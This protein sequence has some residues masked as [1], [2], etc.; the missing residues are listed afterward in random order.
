MP[1][2]D[3]KKGELLMCQLCVD[4]C[5]AV[6]QE[7]GGTRGRENEV[8]GEKK[9]RGSAQD[10]PSGIRTSLDCSAAAGAQSTRRETAQGTGTQ[11]LQHSLLSCRDARA[12]VQLLSY[13]GR[14]LE[15]AFCLLLFLLGALHCDSGARWRAGV[16]CAQTLRGELGLDMPQVKRSGAAGSGPV[17]GAER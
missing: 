11:S 9:K 16:L 3:L 13:L 4:A 5:V 1:C 12:R 2:P 8:G 17:R 6:R 15:V 14:I 7:Q 10:S